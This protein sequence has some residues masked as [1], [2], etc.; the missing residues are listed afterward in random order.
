MST[1][2]SA[3]LRKCQFRGCST[4]LS[5]DLTSAF[6]TEHVQKDLKALTGL[7]Y[8]KVF[9]VNRVGREIKA[10]TYQFLTQ[11]EFE[12]KQKSAEKRAHYKLHMPPVM[13]ERTPI[14]KTIESDP[15]LKG[16]NATKYVFTDISFGIHDRERLITVREANGDLRTAEWDERDRLN[17]IYFPKPGRRIKHPPLFISKNLEKILNPSKYEYILAKNCEQFEPDHPLY[18]QTAN[19]VF[20]HADQHR[21]YDVLW[22][23]RFYG[24]LIYTL[25]MKN[26]IDNI[27]IHYFIKKDV[28]SALRVLRVYGE[29]HDLNSLKE[30][31]N[32][33]DELI[34][35]YLDNYS[36]KKSKVQKSYE[37]MLELLKKDKEAM[38]AKKRA[39]GIQDDTMDS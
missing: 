10:P 2:M 11:E 34:H 19:A 15:G 1:R 7:N 36:S 29:I 32:E 23:T 38:E 3:L 37:T 28:D 24:P 9:R 33:N 16:L 30:L 31:K 6:F 5:K 18:L 4:S 20:E 8:D 21:Q 17:Q 12:E 22:S 25:A 13:H 14:S 27:L 39:H 35:K 26:S